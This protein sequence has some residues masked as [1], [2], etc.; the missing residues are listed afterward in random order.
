[1]FSERIHVF[2]NSSDV[3]WFVSHPEYPRK[4]RI[5][6]LFNLPSV[7]S[8]RSLFQNYLPNIIPCE[9]SILFGMCSGIL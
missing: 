2:A 9:I 6:E 7:E 5:S 1:M 4:N 8:I 3:N